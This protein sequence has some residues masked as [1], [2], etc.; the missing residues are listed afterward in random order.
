MSR[1]RSINFI[2]NNYNDNDIKKIKSIEKKFNITFIMICKI[3]D[4]RLNI[5]IHFKNPLRF[6]SILKE[7][8]K[9]KQTIIYNDPIK[10]FN[11][12]KKGCDDSNI[13][14]KGEI[15]EN[16]KQITKKKVEED[17]RKGIPIKVISEKYPMWY[18]IHKKKLI[19]YYTEKGLI[20][21]KNKEKKFCIIPIEHKIY[22]AKNCTSVFLL[23]GTDYETYENEDVV[24]MANYNYGE[25]KI[26]NWFNGFPEKFKRGYE[27]CSF[28]PNIIYVL[29]ESQKEYNGLLLKF[30]R[31]IDIEHSISYKQNINGIS[32]KVE[33]NLI[34]KKEKEKEKEK[35][36]INDIDFIGT[37]DKNKIDELTELYELDKS[38]RKKLDFDWERINVLH[39]KI[40]I[41]NLVIDDEIDDIFITFEK[42]KNKEDDDIEFIEDSDN[43]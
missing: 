33:N 20:S 8:K 2:I 42:N 41:P 40:K 6:S 18:M 28:N 36:I 32:F 19:D 7:I 5:F 37:D 25:N 27:I 4:E 3:N 29:Y 10:N 1:S 31:F 30:R 39:E 34:V 9:A 23:E 11:W 35:E 38:L 16:G 17:I 15:P 26:E 22:I 21:I 12:C 13:W 14:Y 43:E 24:I